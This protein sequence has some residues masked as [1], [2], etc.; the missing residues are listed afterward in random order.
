M[1]RTPSRLV[2]LWCWYHGTR[3][4][5]YQAQ[6]DAVTV[7]ATL[8]AALL[9]A[10]LERSPVASGRTDAGVHARML[11]LSLRVLDGGPLDELPG[12]IN[13]HLPGDLGI[14]LARPAPAHFN[15]QWRSRVKEYRY[16]LLTGARPDWA[17]FG[18]PVEVDPTRLEGVLRRAVGTFDYSAFH[19]PSSAVK[20][21][22][23]RAIEVARGRDG[24]VDVRVRGE[25][26]GRYMVRSLVGAAVAVARAEWSVDGFEA[27]LASG[28]SAEGL[29][30]PGR[31]SRRF[32]APAAGLTLWNV[33]YDA[34]DDP[35]TAE[36]RR[37][38]QGL[39]L[40]P[41]FVED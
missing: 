37:T 18:W 23:I 28:S 35:F 4:R 26:F 7:Q 32:R 24:L 22:T 17:P 34:V 30:S 14:A 20:P 12:R 10:G 6:A 38:A 31:P 11:V 39:P 16:R 1:S 36:E 8:K 27:A 15:A 2:A 41:P 5:G 3:F 13:A 29:D 21:R 19:D 40:A 33:E 9:K 25:G